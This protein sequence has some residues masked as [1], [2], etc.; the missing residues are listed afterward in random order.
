MDWSFSKLSL[1][2]KPR[3]RLLDLPP[4]LRDMIFTF[5]LTSS[6]PIVSFRLDEYQKQSYQEVIQPPLTKVSRQIRR[7][8]LPIFFSCN[9]IILHTESTKSRDSQR[10]LQCIE[11]HIPLLHRISI[12]VR[13]VTLTHEPTSGNGAISINLQR[14]K[15]EGTWAV[16]DEWRWITVT[17]KPS[18]VHRDAE[19][20]IMQLR[21]LVAED[22]G[23]TG[24]A[25]GWMGLR[26]DLQLGYVKEKMS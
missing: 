7:E 6:K 10:W 25:E 12:W 15:P 5:A 1:S 11:H 8:T 2:N 26:S 18:I 9:S 20:L 17:R 23:C 22:E 14:R 4:E 3:S 21:R 16:M 13:Y 19:F 24:T